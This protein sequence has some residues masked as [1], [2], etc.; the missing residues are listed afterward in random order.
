MKR[1]FSRSA[2]GAFSG[3]DTP[4]LGLFELADKGT[5]FLDEIGELDAKMQV[6]LLRVLDRVPYYRLGGHKKISVDV[7]VLA[8]SNQ[9]LPRLIRAMVDQLTSPR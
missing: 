4:K 9:D 5:L 7:R 2:A 3:A 8:A 6:K 1:V